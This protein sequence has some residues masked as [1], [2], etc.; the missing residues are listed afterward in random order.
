MLFSRS[1]FGTCG[2]EAVNL[3]E[4]VVIIHKVGQYGY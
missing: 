3:K 4:N 1:E 2:I